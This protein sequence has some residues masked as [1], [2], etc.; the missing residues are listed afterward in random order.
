MENNNNNYLTKNPD[1]SFQL[2]N[3]SNKAIKKKQNTGASVEDWFG[4]NHFSDEKK[5]KLY[6][7]SKLPTGESKFKIRLK[8]KDK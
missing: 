7:M 5:I 8:Y 1:L 4:Q 2:K 3:F 6:K